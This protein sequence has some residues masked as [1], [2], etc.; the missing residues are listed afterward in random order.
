MKL[1][2]KIACMQVKRP[3]KIDKYHLK[4]L[5]DTHSKIPA[6]ELHKSKVTSK[7]KKKGYKTVSNLF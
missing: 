5:Q 7:Q 1:N 2:L 4:I 3:M 6:K